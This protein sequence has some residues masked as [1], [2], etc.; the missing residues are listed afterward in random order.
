MSQ[1][2]Q[3]IK[4]QQQQIQFQ[5]KQIQQ[6][7]QLMEQQQEIDE[8][9]QEMLHDELKNQFKLQ[10]VSFILGGMALIGAFAWKEV[11]EETTKLFL[12]KTESVG[13]KSKIISAFVITSI[14]VIITYLLYKYSGISKENIMKSN[15]KLI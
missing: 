7:Q 14:I 12:P 13:L 6:Q 9:Q 3:Q 8:K 15:N 11:L 5:Q 2:Q 4:Q 10:A 1:Q